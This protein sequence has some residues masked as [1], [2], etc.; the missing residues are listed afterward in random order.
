MGITPPD[1]EPDVNL[2][3]ADG[4]LRVALNLQ[5]RQVHFQSRGEIDVGGLCW[6][7]HE[8]TS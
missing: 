7:S 5:R 3:V 1:K 6:S 4:E 2:A 8:E